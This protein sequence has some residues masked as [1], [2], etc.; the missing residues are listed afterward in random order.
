MP[1]QNDLRFEV[2]IDK[3]GNQPVVRVKDL[4]D[5]GGIPL[6]NVFIFLTINGPLGLIHAFQPGTPDIERGTSDVSDDFLIPLTSDGEVP[7]GTYTVDVDVDADGDPYT[8][9]TQFEYTFVAPTPELKAE[10]S[11][12]LSTFKSIDST[13]YT[14]DGHEFISATKKHDVT[15][16]SASGNPKEQT[17]ATEVE[18]GPNIWTGKYYSLLQTT[19]KYLIQTDV[20]LICVLN[21]GATVKVSC[22]IDFCKIPTGLKSLIDKRDCMKNKSSGEYQRLDFII[23]RVSE[24]L[25]LVNSSKNCGNIKLVEQIYKQAFSY[26]EKENCGCSVQLVPDAPKEI[27]PIEKIDCCPNLYVEW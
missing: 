19:P 13:N 25:S 3:T 26:L 20:I 24:L 7:F 15:W 8:W 16:P 23:S 10:Y 5:Y 6:A 2:T 27:I 22:D 4:S 14:V 18:L 9:N 21:V 12:L 17:T 11:C 1:L